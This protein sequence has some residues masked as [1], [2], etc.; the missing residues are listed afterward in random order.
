MS[1]AVDMTKMSADGVPSLPLGKKLPYLPGDL[2]FLLVQSCLKIENG[3]LEEWN[4]GLC[5]KL[6]HPLEYVPILQQHDALPDCGLCV[7]SCRVADD[8]T[9]GVFLEA[10]KDG[11]SLRLRIGDR[12]A[13][14]DKAVVSFV[15]GKYELVDVLKIFGVERMTEAIENFIQELQGAFLSD[16]TDDFVPPED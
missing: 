8:P 12:G 7:V 10:S 14:D 2:G 5:N 16:T 13:V 3:S 6:A 11:K 4:Q 9:R 1:A 15:V